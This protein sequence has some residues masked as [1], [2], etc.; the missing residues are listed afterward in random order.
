M[1]DRVV[2]VLRKELTDMIRDRRSLANA[3]LSALLGP[4]MLLILLSVIGMTV[5]Q[6][7][8]RPLELPVA[9][10]ERAPDLMA[11]LEQRNVQIVPA[12]ADP[13]AAV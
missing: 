12:P 8:E 2:I 5:E 10:P 3:L 11:F 6:Q 9:N 7:T 4:L 1:F 13:A